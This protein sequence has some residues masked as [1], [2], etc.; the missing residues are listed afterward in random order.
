MRVFYTPDMIFIK[1]QCKYYKNNRPDDPASVFHNHACPCIMSCNRKYR[2]F[3][4]PSM[5]TIFPLSRNTTRAATLE[6][7]LVTFMVPD[8]FATLIFPSPVYRSRRKVPVLGHKNHHSIPQQ[9]NTGHRSESVSFWRSLRL[10][11]PYSSYAVHKKQLPEVPGSAYN[12]RFY[13]WQQV[14]HVLPLLIPEAPSGYTG[15]PESSL[16]IYSYTDV[17]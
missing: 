11:H 6:E 13:H 14:L 7:R 17:P 10:F 3:A 2:C 12:A 5:I 8:A 15:V 9:E 1:K 4:I 16:Q